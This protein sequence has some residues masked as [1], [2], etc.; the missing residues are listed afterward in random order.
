MNHHVVKFLDL[1]LD[2]KNETFSPF[3]K[4]N[5][6]PLYID[7]RSNHPPSIINHI[8]SSINKR[9][10]SLSSDQTSF[11]SAAPF[12]EDALKRSNYDVPL[13]YS[14]SDNSSSLP[15]TNR[16]RRRNIIWFNPPFSETV[17]TNVGR[18]FLQLIDK[19]F[20]STNPLHKVFNRNTVKVSY[21]CMENVKTI[22]SRHNHRLLKRNPTQKPLQCNCQKPDECPL[23]GKCKVHNIVCEDMV[24]TTD[25][26]NTK[27]YIGMTANTFKERYA[28]HKTSF[29]L[30]NHSSDTK[31]SKYV[32][33]LKRSRR[34]YNIKWSILKRAAAYTPGG[35]RCGLCLEEKLCILKA[36][37]NKSLNTRSGF[38][39]KCCHKE[40]FSA[41]K[42]KLM[43]QD[44]PPRQRP[45]VEVGES[46]IH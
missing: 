22:I 43:T 4:P 39:A 41:S 7:N 21:S 33:S 8:P 14:A 29:N 26:E 38:C 18:N 1:T 13:Q 24:T 44:K 16:R 12:Y 20:P 19:H 35:K 9:I 15:S 2:L 45:T 11:Y 27:E 3:R 42:F 36:K 5:N 30:Y 25:D 34:N 40:K 46:N 37:G 10:S 31:L 32:W 17:R 23:D 6:D 28:N